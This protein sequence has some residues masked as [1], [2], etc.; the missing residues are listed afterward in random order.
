[1]EVEGRNS[2]P[3]KGLEMEDSFGNKINMMIVFF[4]KKKKIWGGWRSCLPF[5][6]YFIMPRLNN[7]TAKV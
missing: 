7:R 4:S 1:M 5:P 3:T 6:A 2:N